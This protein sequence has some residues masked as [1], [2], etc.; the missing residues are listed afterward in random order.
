MKVGA[1][2]PNKI[3]V[4]T[5]CIHLVVSETDAGTPTDRRSATTHPYSYFF[6]VFLFC[7]NATENKSIGVVVFFFV[8]LPSIF[9]V[10]PSKRSYSR[11]SGVVLQHTIHQQITATN[12]T[13]QTHNTPQRTSLSTRRGHRSKSNKTSCRI[14]G[15]GKNN[16]H[17]T[18]RSQ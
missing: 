13:Q 9:F 15:G 2:P 5:L 1:S 7:V 4:S 6:F 11:E 18:W 10:V 14:V 16:A 17:H 12:T 8:F 3:S